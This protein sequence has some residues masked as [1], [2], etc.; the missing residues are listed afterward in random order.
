MEW[1]GVAKENKDNSVILA[2]QQEDKLVADCARMEV[3]ELSIFNSEV[4]NPICMLMRF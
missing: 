3:Q 1:G 2:K 4:N